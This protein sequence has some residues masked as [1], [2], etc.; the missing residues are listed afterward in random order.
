MRLTVLQSR[1]QV[2]VLI[3]VLQLG[4]EARELLDFK[5][6]FDI[7]LHDPKAIAVETVLCGIGLLKIEQTSR[8]YQ[9]F[10][11]MAPSHNNYKSQRDLQEFYHQN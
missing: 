2:S 11:L 5:K 4:I 8:L 1:F 6:A 7:V 9:S 10:L 3:D